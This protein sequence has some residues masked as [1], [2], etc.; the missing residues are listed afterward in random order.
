ME[1]PNQKRNII[2]IVIMLIVVL[3]VASFFLK[4]TAGVLG[5]FKTLFYLSIFATIIFVVGVLVYNLFFKKEQIDVTFKHKQG[6]IRAGKI[7]KPEF[8]KELWC[9]GDK[10][11]QSVKIGRIL[12]YARI[13]N[14]GGVVTET[15]GDKTTKKDSQKKRQEDVFVVQTT[16]FFASFF[17][18]PI[19]VRVSPEDW[20]GLSRIYI[21]GINLVEVG[22]YYYLNKDMLNFDMVDVTQ[23]SEALRDVTLDSYSDYMTL[24]KRAEGL[25]TE[26]N[27][28]MDKKK[29]MRL[30]QFKRDDD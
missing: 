16:G 29:L 24:I 13:E 22:Q 2:I 8:M 30:P 20:N 7:N 15:E 19:L 14:Y 5:F 23:K 10:T 26:F 18:D 9:K 28:E 12:G 11:H 17:N 6:L 25:D 3:L 4:G 21:N 1:N 27:K